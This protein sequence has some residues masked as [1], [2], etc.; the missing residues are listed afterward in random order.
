[1]SNDPSATLNRSPAGAAGPD[2]GDI[3]RRYPGSREYLIP[4]L[5]DIQER[6]GYLSQDSICRV[7]DHLRLPESKVFGVATFYNQ[8]KLNA[9]GKYLIQLCRGTACHV[10]GSF[11]LL[12]ALKSELGVEEGQTTRD[13]LFT[14]EVVA[15][16]GCCSLAP[17]VN[18]NGEYY[19][20]LDKKKLAGLI[21]EF[22]K[23]E[24]GRAV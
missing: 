12:E 13:G 19:G 14:L 2:I 9:P 17:V 23:R 24:P 7:A 18:I 5:Q 1:M 21:E 22:R 4:L 6:A 20:R 11:D 10:K 15:C 3:L 16:I 8:F